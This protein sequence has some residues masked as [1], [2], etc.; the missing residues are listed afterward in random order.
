MADHNANTR[1]LQQAS[2][3]EAESHGLPWDGTE[4]ELLLEGAEAAETAALLG[5][6]VYAVQSKR[7]ALRAGGGN[8]VRRSTPAMRE[9]QAWAP[10]DPRWDW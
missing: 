2:L 4:V 8:G 9:A 7:H 1:R 6:T 3:L 10:D 5:R